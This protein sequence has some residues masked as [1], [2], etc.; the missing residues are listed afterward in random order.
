MNN[1]LHKI[2]PHT[3]LCI[4]LMRYYYC[5]SILKLK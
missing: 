2:K 1:V 5:L 4:F 3:F